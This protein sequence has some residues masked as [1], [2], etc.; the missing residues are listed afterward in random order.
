MRREKMS[1]FKLTVDYEMSH[2]DSPVGNF[3]EDF[4]VDAKDVQ[5]VKYYYHKYTHENYT[6][7]SRALEEMHVHPIADD[8]QHSIREIAEVDYING[9]SHL[10]QV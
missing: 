5:Y 9:L 3:T 2:N 7:V 8:I 1:L 4:W 6:D 10:R